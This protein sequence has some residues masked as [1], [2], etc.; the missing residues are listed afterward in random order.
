MRG[1][2]GSGKSHLAKTLVPKDNIFSTDDFW[3]PEYNF[4]FKKLFVAH[5]WNQE[6]VEHA[7]VALVP[8]IACDNTNTTLKEM[9]P[10]IELAEEYGYEVELHEP[11]TDWWMECLEAVQSN[12]AVRVTKAI[13]LLSEYG[14]HDVPKETLNKMLNR[15]VPTS[16][17]VL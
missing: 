13:E 9:E 3:G 15:W 10:Y 16:E 8:N 12:D 4:D 7:M 14:T 11:T 1:L 2:P 17:I 6:R 5:K